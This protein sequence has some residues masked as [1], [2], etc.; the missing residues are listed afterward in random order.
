MH[1]TKRKRGSSPLCK[2][3]YRPLAG[4]P[5]LQLHEQ[6]GGQGGCWLFGPPPAVP[7]AEGGGC[8]FSVAAGAGVVLVAVAVAAW[9]GGGVLAVAAGEVFFLLLLRMGSS[10]LGVP[11]DL[12]GARSKPGAHE[13]PPAGHPENSRS[14]YVAFVLTVFFCGWGVVLLLFG[15]PGSS[16]TC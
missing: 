4:L 13:R 10:H 11:D 6:S 15:P 8:F 14:D 1:S 7:L 16:L 2:P 3:N 9:G 12:W 5:G